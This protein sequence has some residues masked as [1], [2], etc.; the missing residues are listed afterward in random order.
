MI[1]MENLEIKQFSYNWQN[2]F[3]RKK[4][5]LLFLYI[6]IIFKLFGTVKNIS[7]G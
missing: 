1:C 3:S 4:E 2:E 7:G 5:Y 6:Y